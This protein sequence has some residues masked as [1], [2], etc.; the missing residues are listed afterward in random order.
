MNKKFIGTRI[1]RHVR[2]IALLCIVFLSVSPLALAEVAQTDTAEAV[3]S[4]EAKV[5]TNQSQSA[6]QIKEVVVPQTDPVAPQ[7]EPEKKDAKPSV[8]PKQK[9]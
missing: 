2:L 9:P 7:V 1:Y 5:E 3:A 6:D 4:T 8:T